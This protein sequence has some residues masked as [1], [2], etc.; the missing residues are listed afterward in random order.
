MFERLLLRALERLEQEK[1]PVKFLNGYF[2]IVNNPNGP[3]GWSDSD[4]L[5]QKSLKPFK[6]RM[7]L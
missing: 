5:H 7:L 3:L 1:I 6:K 4:A 2:E